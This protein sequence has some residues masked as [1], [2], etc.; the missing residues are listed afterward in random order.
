[1]INN[2]A[3]NYE[4]AYVFSHSFPTIYQQLDQMITIWNKLLHP[5][6]TK[7]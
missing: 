5:L 7:S 3:T 1:M 4:L 2:L 6:K